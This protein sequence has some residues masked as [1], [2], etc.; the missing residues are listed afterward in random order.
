MFLNLDEVF[1]IMEQLADVTLRRLLDNEVFDL[2]PDLQEPSQI[3][4]RQGVSS[5]VSPT[6]TSAPQF[7]SASIPSLCGCPSVPTGHWFQDLSLYTPKPV[8]APVPYVNGRV[9]SCNQCTSSRCFKSSID[10][11]GQLRQFKCY[12]NCYTVYQ[13]IPARKKDC[14]YLIQ[15]EYF[16]LNI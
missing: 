11:L 9:F 13:G 16:F 4:K 3:T 2:D 10:D 6:C 7:C 1:K 5:I 15:I 12:I 14:A 8:D